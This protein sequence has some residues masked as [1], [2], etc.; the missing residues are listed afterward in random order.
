MRAL[1]ARLRPPEPP[2]GPLARG[3]HED[4]PTEVL[5]DI[6][7]TLEAISGVKLL[8][9]TCDRDE[10]R[11]DPLQD[12]RD[13]KGLPWMPIEESR[14]MK[15]TLAFRV[16]MRERTGVMLTSEEKVQLYYPK[17]LQGYYFRLG[18]STLFPIWQIVDAET[19]RS[20]RGVTIKTMVMPTQVERAEEDK[21]RVRLLEDEGGSGLRLSGRIFYL[22]LFKKKINI[23]HYFFNKMGL[24]ETLEFMGYDRS[25]MGVVS[26][27]KA[28]KWVEAG[29]AVFPA[30]KALWVFASREVLQD[31]H[32]NDVVST[33][34]DSLH[35]RVTR[36]K[37]M[38]E[39]YWNARLGEH[40]TANNSGFIE[41]GKT[42]ISSVGRILDTRTR[43]IMRVPDSDKETIYHVMRWVMRNYDALRR[44]SPMDMTNKR[45]RRHEYLQYPLLK[46]WSDSSYRLLNS[47]VVTL[48]QGKTLFSN[49]RPN[50]LLKSIGHS[51]LLR[52]S[53]TVNG[54]DLF[55][56]GLRYTLTGPQTASSGNRNVSPQ[57]RG[58]HE[59]Y[60]G[61][62]SL[63][64]SSNGEPGM[65]GT[66]CP[67]AQ[68]DKS[69][70]FTARPGERGES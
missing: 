26:E 39:E 21:P 69:G 31:P 57:A 24:K 43:A 56:S 61:R 30:T 46:K 59:S 22:R 52:H 48:K 4:D 60:V 19:F 6:A 66:L 12:S 23:F 25:D 47:R 50:F 17:L 5:T 64:V 55:S 70:F 16:E 67:W 41:K 65:S 58:I 11:F 13:P 8:S 33:L 36:A 32:G 9:V 35:K 51:E 34:V 44:I 27:D 53:S 54:M 7:R 28:H 10:S 18:G 3:D 15:I 62:V 20:S 68:V 38:K 49:I 37:A 2:F 45:V 14:V 63:N 40:F 29:Y 1:Q 42:L